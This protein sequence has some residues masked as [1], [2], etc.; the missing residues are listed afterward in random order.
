MPHM[1]SI[2]PIM[3]DRRY[4]PTRKGQA[5]KTLYTYHSGAAW[6]GRGKNQMLILKRTTR[7]M[8]AE[9]KAASLPE[10]TKGK[11]FARA[12]RR[13]EERPVVKAAKRNAKVKGI[14][15]KR[16]LRFHGRMALL[17]LRLKREERSTSNT[18]NE[19]GA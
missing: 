16:G 10:P 2:V 5:G 8:E 1:S 13:R 9:L 15:T 7:V 3:A 6:W 18:T 11:S 4:Y 17:G 12:Q 14:R 19:R